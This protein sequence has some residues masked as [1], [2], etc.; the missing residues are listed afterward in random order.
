LDYCSDSKQPTNSYFFKIPN[1]KK[2]NYWPKQPRNS[3]LF[4][5]LQDPNSQRWTGHHH[6]LC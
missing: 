2:W 6:F 5:F 3:F 4:F 1:S